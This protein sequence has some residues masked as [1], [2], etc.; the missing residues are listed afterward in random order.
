MVLLLNWR[1]LNSSWTTTRT[2]RCRWRS[3]ERSSSSKST[4]LKVG[5]RSCRF[6]YITFDKLYI[7]FSKNKIKFTLKT[8]IIPASTTWGRRVQAE[9]HSWE[10]WSSSPVWRGGEERCHPEQ[11]QEQ[12]DHPAGGCQEAC[13]CRDEGENQLAWQD[14]VSLTQSMWTCLS[15]LGNSWGTFNMSLK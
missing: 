8:L 13:W 9:D 10:L 1:S 11:G 7:S 6:E 2:R 4:T 12:L 5:S 14:E 3:T 15:Y